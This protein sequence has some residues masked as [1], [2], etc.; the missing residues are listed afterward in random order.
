MRLMTAGTDSM[1]P[2]QRLSAREFLQDS[3]SGMTNS[4]L[5]EK[6]K[7]SPNK[8]QRIF[9][10]MINRGIMT[11]DELAGR[12]AFLDHT[13]HAGIQSHRLLFRHVVDFLVQICERQ[14]TKILG[15]VQD[16]T[17]GGVRLKGIEATIGESKNFI[18]PPNKFFDVPQIEFQAQCCWVNREKSTGKCVGGFEITSISP[19]A[20]VDLRELVQ[21][22]ELANQVEV[23]ESDEAYPG[24]TDR[25]GQPRYSVWFT[26]HI[27][28][29]PK[30]ENRG[31]IVDVSEGG[32]GVKGLS[33]E[34]GE[35]KAL[36]I[37]AYYGFVTFD[38][39]VIIAECRWTGTDEETGEKNSGF[40]VLQLTPRNAEEFAKLVSTLSER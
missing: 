12:Y 7:L 24:K 6:Y 34:P 23:I 16:I 25:R 30:R 17:E 33:A 36:V 27:H 4:E 28:E 20:L 13:V 29:A 18:I 21:L 26:L 2:K 15:I 35:K 19:R 39:I 37:P 14:K 1:S 11:K 8:L 3:R 22:I 38:S 31:V 9:R 10:A 5:L 40:K 32:I